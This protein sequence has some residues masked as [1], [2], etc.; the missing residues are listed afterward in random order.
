MKFGWIMPVLLLGSLLAS[1]AA[2]PKQSGATFDRVGQELASAMA[3]KPRASDDA[4]NQAMLPP[5]QLD[6][7]ETAQ[8]VEP[9]FD[10]AVSN[11]PANQVFMALVSGTRYSMLLAPGVEDGK[12]TVNL[13]NVTVRESLE[14]LRELYAYEFKFQGTRIYIQPNTMQT[15]VFQINYL[16]GR[17]L[18]QS[19][20]RVSSSTLSNTP[21]TAGTAAQGYY[22]TNTATGTMPG[23]SPVSQPGMMNSMVG[24]SSRISTSTD[25]DFW[26][27]LKQA[28]QAIVGEDGGRAVILTPASGVV[29]VK[30]YPADIRAVENYLRATQII[31]GRTRRSPRR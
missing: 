19:D 24:P 15:R 10:L 23:T 18:G 29:L 5:L 25:N 31:A 4:V 16:S 28:L 27:E 7:P 11:A 22:P 13:K 12:I 1:C 30:G 17:R 21:G 26:K 2:P 20:L 8:S 14:A 3:S 9:R 6:L